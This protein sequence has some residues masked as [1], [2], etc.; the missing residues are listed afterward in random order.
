MVLK[1][2]ES[3][4]LPSLGEENQKQPIQLKQRRSAD[5]SGAGVSEVENGKSCCL[6]QPIRVLNQLALMDSEEYQHRLCN[7]RLPQVENPQFSQLENAIHRLQTRTINL[8]QENDHQTQQMI[9]I[10]E[11]FCLSKER[12]KKLEKVVTKILTR[13][14]RLQDQSRSDKS[15]A[16]K[17]ERS[18]SDSRSVI[19]SN[20]IHSSVLEDGVATVKLHRNRN[21]SWPHVDFAYEP[22]DGNMK[23]LPSAPPQKVSDSNPFSMFLASKP[24]Q[25][26][27]LNLQKPWTMQYVEIQ[28]PVSHDSV[29]EA[30]EP[31]FETAFAVCGYHGFDSSINCKPTIGARLLKINQEPIQ[32][33]WT[34]EQLLEK[35]EVQGSSILLTFRND[36]WNKAQKKILKQAIQEQTH[37]TVKAIDIGMPIH[38]RTPSGEDIHDKKLNL[39]SF[40]SLSTTSNP[41]NGNGGDEASVP[42][43]RDTLPS[44]DV[45][46]SGGSSSSLLKNYHDTA[47]NSMVTSFWKKLPN[48]DL[49]DGIVFP[50]LGNDVSAGGDLGSGGEPSKETQYEDKESIEL[51]EDNGKQDVD[52]PQTQA[53]DTFKS[54][55]KNMGKLFSFGRKDG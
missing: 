12:V 11:E 32:S 45:D 36:A 7:N 29:S 55:M 10:Q 22:D 17:R 14:K 13:N 35:L 15:L 21:L 50:S 54:S 6:I 31:H 16:Q 42:H 5:E 40:L 18:E 38:R 26:Y 34:M 47:L 24:V 49:D 1:Q 46:G 43:C 37:S 51:P 2:S 3:P 9:D 28:V 27:G 19:S 25:S 30:S 4:T 39:L 8:V 33:A 48:P 41:A 52:E 20:S 23:E 53:D 44:G